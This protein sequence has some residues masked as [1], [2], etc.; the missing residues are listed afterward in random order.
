[1][2][3]IIFDFDGTLADT[4]Q[5]II[6]TLQATLKEL[7]LSEAE[8][9]Q[10]KNLIGLPLRDTFVQAGHIQDPDLL[11]KAIGIYR[12]K[13]PDISLH[14]VR[15]FPH[16]KGTLKDLHRQGITIAIASSKGKDALSQLL[17]SLD[18]RQYITMT[19]GEQDVKNKKPAPDIVLKILSEIQTEPQDTLVVGD[20]TYDVIMGQNA[21]CHTCGVTYGNHTVEQ[22][23]QQGADFIVDDFVEILDIQKG[24]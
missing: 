22:L 10:I 18:I 17:Q 20:T 11:E 1:M 6:Q 21:G 16:V 7:H 2:K 9:E 3:T 23:R 19:C 5:S 24:G 15:L 14:S 4:R 12:E 8:E 13:Y